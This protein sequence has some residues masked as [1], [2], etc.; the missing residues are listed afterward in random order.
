MLLL[1]SASGLVRSVEAADVEADV[2][3]AFVGLGL[4]T[5]LSRSRNRKSRFFGDVR[6]D[7]GI[8]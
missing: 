3:E 6:G 5:G 8:A 1:E 7:E 2:Y 4:V